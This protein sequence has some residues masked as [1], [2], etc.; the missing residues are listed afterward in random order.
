MK[1]LQ[2]VN[3]RCLHICLQPLQ[4]NKCITFKVPLSLALV[5]FVR[6]PYVNL[7]E[8]ELPCAN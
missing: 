5:L 4:V 2:D 8:L 7:A 1:M 6:K 3:K